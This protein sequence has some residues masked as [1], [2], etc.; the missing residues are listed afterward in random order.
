[1]WS[2]NDD[3]NKLRQNH[4]P[5]EVVDVR[6]RSRVGRPRSSDRLQ[7]LRIRVRAAEPA[8]EPR[9]AALNNNKHKMERWAQNGTH[10]KQ[11]KATPRPRHFESRGSRFASKRKVDATGK[12]IRN[13]ISSC[14][15][16]SPLKQARVVSRIY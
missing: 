16:R 11:K 8:L 1:M 10:V 5:G 6:E 9:R 15:M 7:R 2:N 14:P 13:Q 4:A 3:D 12:E